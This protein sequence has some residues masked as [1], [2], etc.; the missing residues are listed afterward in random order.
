MKTGDKFSKEFKVTEDIYQGF[1]SL[2]NDRN[3]IHRD[4]S[5]A[6]QKGFKDVVMFGN[7]LNGFISCFFGELLSDKSVIIQTQNIKYFNPVYLN[8]ELV[9]IAEIVDVFESVNLV[10]FKYTFTKDINLKIA[11]GKIQI[12]IL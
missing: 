12:G 10:E 8:D 1:M 9:L 2:F 5:L 3:P 4:R 6:K 11:N 7:I